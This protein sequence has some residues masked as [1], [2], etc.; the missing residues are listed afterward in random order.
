MKIK[1]I[2][3]TERTLSFEFYPPKRTE[4]VGSVFKTIKQME[5]YCPN[6]ISITYGAGGSTQVF[7]EEIAVRAQKELDVEVMCH[8][9]CAGRSREELHE[10][11]ERLSQAGLDNVIGLRGDNSG[12]N[13]EMFVP[14]KDGFAHATELIEYIKHNFS[15]GIAA[16]CY[17]QGHPQA[18]DLTTDLEY[19]KRKVELGA[20]FLITQLFYDN[21]HFF[22]FLDRARKIGI[23]VPI[24]AGVLPILNTAQIRRFTALCG[25]KIP[26]A[27]DRK[28]EYFADD[29]E[30][31]RE[32]GV[33]YA[34]DQVRSLL[35]GGVNGIHFY[36]LN[37]TY[38]VPR[39]LCNLGILGE[40]NHADS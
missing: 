40:L 31:V 16:A 26:L 34:T 6:F 30:A 25:V 38:S 17:P 24:L 2:L 13:Q 33:E 28:L 11:L 4:L 22:E 15:F 19:T 18:L 7:T 36:V 9:T 8:L 27:L 21:N 39:I 1:D 5:K 35:D 20:D 32:L 23:D 14:A 12:E 10:L 37:R 3:K 29:E